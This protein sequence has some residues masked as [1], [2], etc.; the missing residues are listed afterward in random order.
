MG[1]RFESL[2]EPGLHGD[3]QLQNAAGVLA[4]LFSAGLGDAL[5]AELLNDVLPG[6]ALTG[7]LQTVAAGGANW[8]LDVAHNPAAAAALATAL[9]DKL[10]ASWGIIGLLDDKDV[11]GIVAP[12]NDHI[13]HWIA[14]T[15][16]SQRALAAEEC[17]RRIANRGNR[18][19]MIGETLRGAMD[20]A[21]R[22]TAGGDRIL[23][24]GSF[25]LVGPALQILEL[26]SRPE[27]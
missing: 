10:G 27:S 26:Y 11:E 12:L 22:H 4:L 9:D 18:P 8:L 23:I 15:A 3:F 7:R 20:Y 19:F 6:L 16:D 21:R 1:Q 13:G 17:A 25:Y 14:V 2:P 24:T 5:T